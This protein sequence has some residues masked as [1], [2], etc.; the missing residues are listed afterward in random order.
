MRK[1]TAILDVHLQT[2]LCMYTHRSI[3][4][5]TH[6]KLGC[7]YFQSNTRYYSTSQVSVRSQWHHQHSMDNPSTPLLSIPKALPALPPRVAAG[8][9]FPQAH[10][11][12]TINS[13][14]M[15]CSRAAGLFCTLFAIPIG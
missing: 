6:S 5:P 12:H 11:P 7:I 4:I 2:H 9:A 14:E 3:Y 13:A 15:P 1:G 8:L 10:Q